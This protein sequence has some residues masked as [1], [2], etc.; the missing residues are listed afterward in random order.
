MQVRETVRPAASRL[1]LP[2]YKTQNRKR[3]VHGK[4]SNLREHTSWPRPRVIWRRRAPL[5]PIACVRCGLFTPY[6][7]RTRSSACAR[8]RR[9]PL[10]PIAC[11]RCGLFIPYDARARSSALYPGGDDPRMLDE[12]PMVD[13]GLGGGGEELVGAC[14][15]ATTAR[16]CWTRAPW[17]TRAPAAAARS[18]SVHVARRRRPAHA[19]RIPHGGRGP[20]RRRR[21]VGRC[22]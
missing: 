11:V 10:F 15:P 18:W 12:S 20:R 14:S 8:R 21:G 9:A 17:V 13:E 2:V 22:M 4:R 5:F 6:D 3:P 16:A 1:F 19:G 7:A